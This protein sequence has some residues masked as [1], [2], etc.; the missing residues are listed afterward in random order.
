MSIWMA[1]YVILWILAA[2]LVVAVIGLY[3]QLGLLHLRMGNTGALDVEGQGPPLGQ[4]VSQMELTDLAG[5]VHEVGVGQEALLVIL[6]V[7]C[8]ACERLLPSLQ[9]YGQDHRTIVVT[10]GVPEAANDLSSR[11][12]K[13]PV[14]WNRRVID[15]FAVTLP[16]FAIRVDSKGLVVGR[17][18]VNNLGQLEELERESLVRSS[19]VTAMDEYP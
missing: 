19:M 18:I 3:R 15:D 16:P 2:V 8:S 9:V 10:G 14:V 6:S 1:S 17:G 5:E 13:V 11:L 12:G 4:K 7:G